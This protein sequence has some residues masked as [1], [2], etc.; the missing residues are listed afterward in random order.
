MTI[1]EL[2]LKPCLVDEEDNE[3]KLEDYTDESWD[4]IYGDTYES[5]IR[6]F[7]EAYS[8]VKFIKFEKKKPYIH[9]ILEKK[10]MSNKQ[11]FIEIFTGNDKE[12]NVIY[13]ED[14]KKFIIKSKIINNFI[15]KPY[16]E[17]DNEFFDNFTENELNQVCKCYKDLF[18]NSQKL[19]GTKGVDKITICEPKEEKNYI[20]IILE[21]YGKNI[22][23]YIDILTGID[24]Q[25]PIIINNDVRIFSEFIDNY[26]EVKSENNKYEKLKNMFAI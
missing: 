13:F 10:Y 23:K 25:N 12:P 8:T 4:E 15:L 3:Q 22:D 2:K 11:Y 5:L 17:I 18:L 7:K 9:I 20:N 24:E 19:C 14:S 1:L 26:N 6:H 16:M 21:T